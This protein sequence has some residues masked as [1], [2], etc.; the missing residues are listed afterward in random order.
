[1]RLTDGL[2]KVKGIG[3]KKRSVLAKMGLHTLNDMLHFFPFRYEDW[4]RL[5][6]VDQLIREEAAVFYGRVTHVE[7]QT[8]GKRSLKIVKAVLE[9]DQGAI[10]ASWYNRYQIEKYLRPHTKVLVYGRVSSRYGLEL[11]VQ[12]HHFISNEAQLKALLTIRPVY[13]LAEGVN[14][15]DMLRLTDAALSCVSELAEPLS[16][17]QC[18]T[19]HLMGYRESVKA[20]HRPLNMTQVEQ[21]FTAQVVYEFLALMLWSRQHHIYKADG[22]AHTEAPVLAEAFVKSLPYELTNAQNRAIESIVKNMQSPQQMHRLL[23]GDVG[24]GKTNVAIYAML[25]AVSN[26]YQAALMAPTEVLA[27]QHYQTITRALAPIGVTVVLLTGQQKKKEKEEALEAIGDGRAQCII[28]THALIEEAVVFNKLS[29]VVIDE[30]HRFGVKQR[31][32]LERKAAS[33]DLLVMTATP[34]PRSLALTVYGDLQLTVIDELPKNRQE[35]QTIWINS[36]REEAMYEF[37]AKE[38]SEGKQAY[39]VCPLVEESEKIDL[40]NAVSLADQLQATFFTSFKVGLLHGRMRADEKEAI[41][42]DFRQRK[43]QL[44]VST[45]VIEVGVDVPNATIMVIVNAERFGLAQLHQLRGRVGRGSEKSYCILISN[46]T[47]EQGQAR[48]KLMATSRNGFEIAE[49]DLRQRGPG[50]LLGLRQHGQGMFKLARPG[51]H[52]VELALAEK[53]AEELEASPLSAGASFLVK[54]LHT[55][56]IP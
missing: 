20:L 16:E 35:I 5:L 51:Y 56:M 38:V 34:I 18:Q 53:I 2:D 30:Q 11:Q 27:R 45:T 1:M 44:L 21:A 39:V 17:E 23:Q 43:I 3:A 40:E 31:E 33:P 26:G 14:K 22:I 55:K 49:E 13:S 10:V 9:G 36:L 12:E 52:Q 48:M 32:A 25:V 29:L 46:T 47:S 28:G 54:K 4:S 24:S 7:V 42:E 41:M 15:V 19:Y 50:E 37:V 6:N 8:P